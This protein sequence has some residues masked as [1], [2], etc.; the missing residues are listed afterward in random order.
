MER[1]LYSIRIF[2]LAWTMLPVLAQAQATKQAQVTKPEAPQTVKILTIGNSFAQ[3]ACTY[4]PPIAE[5][6]AGCE[7]VIGKANIGG[8]HLEKHAN[9]IRQSE[10][11]P[12][13]KPYKGKTLK[14][15]LR[16]EAWDVVT[17]QQVSYLSFE[18]ASYHPHV[19]DIIAYV[20][21]HAPQA[22][23]YLHQ[24]WAYAPDCPRLEG[25]GMDAR[26][27]Y[28]GLKTSYRSLAKQYELP[29]LP[30]G[31][32]FYRASRKDENLHLWRE[33]RFHANAQGCYLAG[34]VWLKELFERS[35]EE[36]IFVP[37]E[38]S[39]EVAAFLRQVAA[40]N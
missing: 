30:S 21:R 14:E 8:C 12:S 19:G 28:K 10:Q 36:V 3:N 16:Q 38:I 20:Q 23:L 5:S 29:I 13:V 6:V 40:R 17:I 35:P 39:P 37:E 7:V 24:T 25:F 27:M 33:D 9:L 1:R 15:W 4:L 34:C 11:D 2:L 31:D 22:Q 26:E 32:A 18:L